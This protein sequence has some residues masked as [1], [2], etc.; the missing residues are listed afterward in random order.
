[1]FLRVTTRHRNTGIAPFSKRISDQMR[2]DK[3]FTQSP[4]GSF[5]LI[6]FSNKWFRAAYGVLRDRGTAWTDGKADTLWG[7]DGGTWIDYPD[8]I[9]DAARRTVTI[10]PG[11]EIVIQRYLIAGRHTA[12][13]QRVASEILR[14]STPRATVTVTSGRAPV[15]GAD[16]AVLQH[17]RELSR[18]YTDEQGR[19]TFRLADGRY[20]LVVSQVGRAAK[21]A[22]LDVQG[23]VYADV[24]LGRPSRVVFD[25]TDQSGRPSP[26]KI[27]F[28]GTNGAADP[29]LGP[30]YRA[31]GCK[32]LYFSHA[33]KFTVPLPAGSYKVIVSRGPEYDAVYRD[34]TLREGATA[35]VAARLVRTVDSRGWIAADFH[36]HTT[37]SGDDVAD[38]DSRLINIVAEGIEFAASTEHN[39]ICSYRPR[40]AALGL[41]AV[42][43]TSDGIEL[44]GRPGPGG[45]N[46]Q[47][48]FPLTPRRGAQNGGAPPTSA[49]PREQIRRLFEFDGGSE[50]L[51]QQNHPQVGWLYFDKNG[52]GQYDGGFGTAQF[53]HVMEVRADP[54]ALLVPTPDSR[55]FAWLQMLNQ[56]F[57]LPGTSNSDGHTCFHE[58]GKVRNYVKS[59]T[60]DPGRIDE[61]E[62]VREA[63][64][65]HIVMGN[66]PFLEVA[67]NGALPGDVVRGRAGRLHVRVQCAN[68]QD[69]DRVQ[70]LLS[71]RPDPKLDFTRAS[72]PQLF[73]DGVV[74][75]ENDAEL[76][77]EADAHIV[78]VVL[79]PT[80]VAPSPVMGPNAA[81]PFAISNPIY[82]DVDG[83]GFQPNKDMLGMPLPVKRKEAEPES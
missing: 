25:V 67:L 30:V 81:I 43:A 17:G 54:R 21:T 60:D 5:P 57:R 48:G 42:L 74:K 23:D 26:C 59:S 19:A 41:Q 80:T 7:P 51:V 9:D 11:Q 65:G 38:R 12:D 18:A 79:G 70:V 75:F 77:L 47:N 78:V 22:V 3:V 14:D 45:I 58:S 29:D 46:H 20:E 63:K 68:W 33:G 1:V 39:R 69:I 71:G 35:S 53:T 50:K 61:M 37:E 24:A 62:I 16:I 73:H 66:G 4:E 8:H 82:V 13:V 52:D 32:N 49:D 34:L 56:G 36:N 6:V 76:S 31:R 64:K 2:C 72:H 44:S 55:F 10:P 15:S 28:L 83:N 27:Q 40:L